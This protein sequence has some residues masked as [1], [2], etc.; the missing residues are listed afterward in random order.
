MT[1]FL[2]GAAGYIGGS[3]ARRLLRDGHTVRGLIRDESRAADLAELGIEPV[4]GSLEDEALLK[5]EAQA[6]S[7]VIHTASSDHLPAVQALLSGLTDSNKPFLHTSGSSVIGDDAEGNQVS[8]A[9]YDEDT[10][11]L[12]APMKQ[13]R[14]DI[15]LHVLGATQFGVRSMVVSPGNIYGTGTGLNPRSVQI[16]Y[17]VDQAKES[18]IVRIVGAGINRWSNVHIEDVAE[19]YVLALK[20]AP[21]GS[22][23]FV[24]NGEDSFIDIAHAIS[25][26]LELDRIES[27]TVEQATQRWGQMHARYTF[28][29]NSRVRAKRAREVLGWTPRHASALAWIESE[30]PI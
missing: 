8:D 28:G 12:V 4:I 23:F 11:F 2:T 24:E 30:M 13:P 25:R 6:A 10:P 3:V 1:I 18:G 7:A 15:E 5:R 21:G 26:R 17:L 27:W 14:R 19:L 9:I 16:P 29:T 22:Y 20:N